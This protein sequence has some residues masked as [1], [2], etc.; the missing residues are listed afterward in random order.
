[1][2]FVAAASFLVVFQE[3]QTAVEAAAW[4]KILADDSLILDQESVV[5]S[6][7][8][9]GGKGV[10]FG[11][12]TNMMTLGMDSGGCNWG[13]MHETFLPVGFGIAFQK[14]TPFKDA[15]DEMC[16]ISFY[17][18]MSFFVCAVYLKMFISFY[19]IVSWIL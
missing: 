2:G 17:E 18:V 10:L 4:Q 5:R 1:M 16:V 12:Y 15:F 9:E 19:E 14:G 3:S 11:D 7:V 8:H 6:I 13:M